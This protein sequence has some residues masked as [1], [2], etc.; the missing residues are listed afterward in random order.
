MVNGQLD[1]DQLLA[2]RRQQL[3]MGGNPGDFDW[4]LDLAGG[5]PWPDQQQLRLHPRQP[6]Q[7][8]RDLNELEALWRRHLETA[9]P[10]QYLVG[11]CPWR[12]LEIRVAPGVLI[13]RQ[14]TE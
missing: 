4:L 9:V 5:L 6:V 11:L 3:D 12:D 1:G 13:P 2:W 7:L 10:L 8:A 14:E